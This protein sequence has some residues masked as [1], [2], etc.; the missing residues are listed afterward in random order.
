MTPKWR[1]LADKLAERIRSGEYAA[2]QRL[3]HIRDLVEAG[4]GSKST[5]HAAYKALE[6][7]G[8]VTSSRGHGTVVR[9][10]APLKRLGI[11]R[12]DKAKWRDGD[13]V[14]FIADRV[15]SG[16]AYRRGE[17]TQTVSR[18]TAPATVASALGV[19]EGADVYAR[20]RLVKED[21]RPTHTLTS[22]YR[23]EH[24]EGTRLV[25]PA[26][27]PAGRGGGFRVLYDAGYE[28]D[29][30]REELHARTATPEEAA[31]LRLAPG[32]W[33]VELHRTAYTADGTVVEFAVGVH[34]A[35]RFAWSYEFEVPD[36]AREEAP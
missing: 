23:P 9:H 14:A 18:T 17:Q 4:E 33:V 8:L 29:R 12:Y 32:E 1:E 26:P 27:G 19:P 30:M 3:P 11:A 10:Q 25:D 13:E 7:E 6:A 16:R 34:A 15:A 31:Q 2:G 21:G 35:T 28:I 24:V 20:A 22:Y 36:S 5:V